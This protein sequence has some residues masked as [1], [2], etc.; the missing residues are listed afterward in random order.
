MTTC[1]FHPTRIATIRCKRCGAPICNDC[2]MVSEVGV[3]CS[4]QC[5]DAIKAFQD[6]VK[7]DVPR[8]RRHPLLSRGA[9]SGLLAIVFLFGM[10]YVILC[11]RAGKILSFPEVMDMMEGWGRFLGTYF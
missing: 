2:K 7:D 11:W 8:R 1:K 3:V 6:R 5:L 9:I 4:P 10:A